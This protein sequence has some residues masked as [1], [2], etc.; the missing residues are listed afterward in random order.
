MRRNR[1][2]IRF[3]FRLASNPQRERSRARPAPSTKRSRATVDAILE[4]F[5]GLQAQL[6]YDEVTT[7]RVAD[8]AGV[9][10]GALYQY[11][12]N[13]EAIAVA[14][15]E[16]TSSRVALRVRDAILEDINESLE[17]TVRKTLAILLRCHRES[18]A[19]LID[20]V[21][22]SP[23]LRQAVRHLSVV[24]LIERSSRIYLEQHSD[25][26]G[27][28]ASDRTRYFMG[29]IVK[30]SMRDYIVNPPKGLSDDA[31][32]DE[33]TKILVAYAKS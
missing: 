22:S 15:F 20:L 19:V 26:L 30:G 27:A 9:S 18:R 3:G 10:V 23:A 33:L 13:K 25:E 14:L 31:F 17:E 1:A 11:F 21:D 5:A 12:P 28:S 29:S 32:V 24:D 2:T 4:A 6:G 8:R 7:T 16:E